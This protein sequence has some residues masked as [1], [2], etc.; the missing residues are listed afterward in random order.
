MEKGVWQSPVTSLSVM[1]EYKPSAQLQ[2][3]CPSCLNPSSFHKWLQGVHVCRKVEVFHGFLPLSFTTILVTCVPEHD[4]CFHS[5]SLSIMTLKAF[6][7]RKIM[8][9]CFCLNEYFSSKPGINQLCEL[10]FKLKSL[11][12]IRGQLF[13][14]HPVWFVESFNIFYSTKTNHFLWWDSFFLPLQPRHVEKKNG[15]TINA[16]WKMDTSTI[17]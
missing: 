13:L 6:Q 15:R 2:M 14:S 16:S 7:C 3:R 11:C 17:E 8:A 10:C 5:P 9:F 4:C 12:Y 1:W